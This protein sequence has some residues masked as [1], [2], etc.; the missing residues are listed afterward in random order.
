[1]AKSVSTYDVYKEFI[2]TKDLKIMLR[3]KKL[4]K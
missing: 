3:K 4:L 2:A 1:V